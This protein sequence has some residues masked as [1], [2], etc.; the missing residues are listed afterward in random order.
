MM[1]TNLELELLIERQG[2][3]LNI[4]F[5]RPSALNALTHQMLKDVYKAIL[6]AGSDP[7]IRAIVISGTGRGF[8]VGADLEKFQED[9]KAGKVP[10]FREELDTYFHPV[11]RAI[12][13]A[14]QIVI[15]KINGT[16]AGAG[17]ALAL[18][19]DLK[20]AVKGAS[21]IAAFAKVGLGPDTGS[22]LF[23]TQALGYSK[24]LDFFLTNGK[25]SAEEAEQWGLINKVCED[26]AALD[27]A[28][29]ETIN[30][31]SELPPQAVTLTKR[32]LMQ[33]AQVPQFEKAI[34]Y[35][36]AIQNF[37]GKTQDHAEGMAAFLEKRKPVFKGN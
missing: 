27:A 35:E 26:G 16:C 18:G 15:G 29:Q 5:N 21:I 3:A 34:N 6:K 22:S 31:L 17:M 32:A 20:Y 2:P 24:A 12:R 36:S 14:P 37:L 7:A 28:V 19:C 25:I 33:A 23:I 10:S 1:R 4:T 30:Q 13:N 11:A 9:S 8:C